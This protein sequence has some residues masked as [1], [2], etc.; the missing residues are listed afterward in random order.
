M[1]G[2][3]KGSVKKVALEAAFYS[4][5]IAIVFAFGLGLSRILTGGG[6]V[7]QYFLSIR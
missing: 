5:L 3:E 6:T 4:F 7:V 2:K 1:C